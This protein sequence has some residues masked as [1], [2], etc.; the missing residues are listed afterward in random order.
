MKNIAVLLVLLVV[1]AGG[2]AGYYTSEGQV[3]KRQ[4]NASLAQFANAVATKDRKAVSA[5]LTR[6]LTDDAKVHLTVNF[7]S[8]GNGRPAMEEHFD[9]AQFITF[10]DNILYTLTDYSYTPHL[11]TLDKESGAVSFTSGEWADGVNM[12]GGVSV[13]MRYSSDTQCEGRV[14]F[15]QS[16]ARLT[17]VSCQMQFRQLPKPGQQQK[18]LNTQ[19]MLGLLGVAQ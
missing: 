8:I 14:I 16:I 10:I 13:D 17:Q 4:V 6:L 9:K 18:F 12:M 7:F 5:V 15:E 1:I 19:G 2:M 3:K 11:Q